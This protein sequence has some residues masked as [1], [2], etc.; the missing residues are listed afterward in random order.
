EAETAVGVL[1]LQRGGGELVIY[2]SRGDEKKFGTT[3]Q[4]RSF[5]GIQQA[6]EV[7]GYQTIRLRRHL[8]GRGRERRSVHD[9]IQVA[10]SDWRQSG[11]I[12][13]IQDTVRDIVTRAGTRLE[14]RVR[15]E[16][17][18]DDLV[19]AAPESSHECLAEEASGAGN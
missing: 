19:A 16:I 8:F 9:A 12:S 1:L 11:R 4:P 7:D 2:T 3:L 5:K 13:D 6:D 17:G 10:K 15:A 18:G 14:C